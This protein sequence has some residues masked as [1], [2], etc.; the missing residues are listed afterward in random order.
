MSEDA[1]EG[2]GSDFKFF[3]DEPEKSKRLVSF[4]P[5]AA[6]VE[7]GAGLVELVDLV[8]L[9]SRSPKPISTFCG[10]GFWYDEVGLAG[11]G[12]VSKKLPPPPPIDEE[13]SCGETTAER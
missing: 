4:D 1:V 11:S 9:R 10:G 13:V 6:R 3:A 2:L 8:E 7:E 12:L 5:A